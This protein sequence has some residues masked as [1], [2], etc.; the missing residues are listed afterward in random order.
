MADPFCI[1]L[2]HA[3]WFTSLPFPKGLILCDTHHGENP[4]S[5][6]LE[7]CKLCKINSIV[8]RFNQRHEQLFRT[9]NIWTDAT[10]VSPDLHLTIKSY[11][12]NEDRILRNDEERIKEAT[13]RNKFK[14]SPNLIKT[15]FI[16]NMKNAHPFR[17]Y[18]IQLL[19]NAGFEVATKVTPGVPEMLRELKENDVGLNLP[20]NGDFMKIHRDN[21]VK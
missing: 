4:L 6:T 19:E 18:Q 13:L 1:P 21:D 11:I 12:N 2:I 10:V 14:D 3:K 16:G 7:F 9:H 15:V 17:K 8:L 5:R 20:L